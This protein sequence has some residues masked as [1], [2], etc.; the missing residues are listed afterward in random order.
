MEYYSVIKKKKQNLAIC[1]NMNGPG[2]YNS[3]CCKS[4]KERQILCDFNYM[5]NLGNKKIN[6]IKQK[7]TYRYREQMS[8]C[9]RRGG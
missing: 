1:G 7:Q 3:M 9:H 4:D 8:G 6:N 2:V 5:W